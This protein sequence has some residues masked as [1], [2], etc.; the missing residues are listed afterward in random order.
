MHTKTKACQISKATREKVYLRDGCHCVLC[1]KW[2]DVSNACAHFIPRSRGGLGIEQNILTLCHDCHTA[3][4]NGNRDTTRQ[5]KE[6]YFR[7]YLQ[8]KYDNWSEEALVYDKWRF[9]KTGKTVK[10]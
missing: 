5:E 3:Y 9:F 4:D 2:A 7:E 1:G 10:G 6:K 8:S